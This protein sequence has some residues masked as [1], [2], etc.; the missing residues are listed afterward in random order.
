MVK[1]RSSARH[2][3]QSAG[4]H[5][6]FSVPPAGARGTLPWFSRRHSP[7]PRRRGS[8]MWRK[9]RRER[10]GCTCRSPRPC[11]PDQFLQGK[12]HPCRRRKTPSQLGNVPLPTAQLASRRKWL[13]GVW[14]VWRDGINNPARKQFFHADNRNCS[15]SSADLHFHDLPFA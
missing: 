14:A 12:P 3:L 9:C 10:Q 5:D 4:G 7:S 2:R 8:T 1:A 15:D 6:L 13:P 11:A